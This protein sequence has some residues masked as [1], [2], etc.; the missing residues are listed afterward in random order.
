MIETTPKSPD[1]QRAG[2]IYV[3]AKP[4]HLLRHITSDAFQI[5]TTVAPHFAVVRV[6]MSVQSCRLLVDHF[7]FQLFSINVVVGGGGVVNGSSTG[8][9]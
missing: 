1:V 7:L 8:V 3:L 2:G 6:T 4:C 9:V 5:N